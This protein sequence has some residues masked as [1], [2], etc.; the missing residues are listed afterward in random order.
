MS[1]KRR[2][3]GLEPLASPVSGF[4]ASVG[5]GVAE[6]QRALDEAALETVDQ[7]YQGD[8]E[9]VEA[10]REIGYRPTWYR[11]PEVS[12]DV[13]VAMRVEG[14]ETRGR[15][16]PSGPQP[17]G[18]MPAGLR[19]VGARLRV[20]AHVTPVDANYRNRFDY[21]VEASSTISFK[22]VPVPAPTA[23][24]GRGEGGG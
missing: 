14:A 9:R 23:V 19:G 13:K 10:L 15:G 12:A 5:Q 17:A 24:E 3:A 20:T 6:A 16:H 1:L 2:M 11:I 21:E 8:G 18:P 22:V 4:I 7:I